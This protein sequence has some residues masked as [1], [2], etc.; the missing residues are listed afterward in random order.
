MAE[1]CQ[2]LLMLSV[3]DLPGRLWACFRSTIVYRTLFSCYKSTVNSTLLTVLSRV[4][5]R[6][7]LHKFSFLILNSLEVMLSN[8]DALLFL[9]RLMAIS[10]LYVDCDRWTS[11][12]CSVYK[13][14]LILS[15]G[16]KPIIGC[17][18]SRWQLCKVVAYHFFLNAIVLTHIVT[19]VLSHKTF[20]SISYIKKLKPAEL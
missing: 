9:T 17:S 5:P 10:R 18:Y 11:S 4:M 7:C 12:K 1:A 20:F 3:H 13:F 6:Q 2:E 8:P 14:G 19:H 16:K 15:F